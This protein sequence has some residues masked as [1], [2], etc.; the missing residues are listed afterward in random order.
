MKLQHCLNELV[1]Q[2]VPKSG[3]CDGLN[4]STV[5]LD[6]APQ[7]AKLNYVVRYVNQLAEHVLSLAK[8]QNVTLTVGDSLIDDCLNTKVK[9]D[10]E[11]SL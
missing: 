9:V 6:R 2:L 10:T 4:Y 1:S 5:E 11:E 8:L 7:H 3:N